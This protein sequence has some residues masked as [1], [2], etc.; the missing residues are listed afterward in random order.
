MQYSV[1]IF[2]AEV[3]QKCQDVDQTLRPS[4]SYF[5]GAGF[6]SAPD[7]SHSP[8]R[9]PLGHEISLPHPIVGRYIVRATDVVR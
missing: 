2:A 8:K 9:F 6:K 4:V 1:K 3:H 5:G 7:D